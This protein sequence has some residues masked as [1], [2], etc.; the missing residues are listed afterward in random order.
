MVEGLP[1]GFTPLID[2][3]VANPEYA[4]VAVF[5]VAAGES[6]LVVGWLLP[7]AIMMFALGALISLGLIPP[8][9]TLVAATAGA[10]CGDLASYL[11]GRHYGPRLFNSA[12]LVRQQKLVERG[13]AL[14]DRHGGKAIFFGRFVGPVRP[15][16][17]AIAGALGMTFH[18]FLL[19]NTLSAL[20][21]A[22]AYLLPGWL[23]GNSLALAGEIARLTISLLLV[24]AATTTSLILTAR[25]LSHDHPLL[26]IPFTILFTT[27][28]WWPATLDHAAI[29]Q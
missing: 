3:I 19:W 10:I 12:L 18:S 9:Q 7:G 25:R 6:L 20:L 8:I 11:I 28:L 13:R 23:A 24:I 2:W 16:I 21:W 5:V 26:L 29:Q 14:A 22:P 4:A 17:P 27:L 1:A 15:V